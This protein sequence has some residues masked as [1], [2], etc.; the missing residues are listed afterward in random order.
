ML[1]R[2]GRKFYLT[3]TEVHPGERH[4]YSM[5][6][7]GGARTR[8]TTMTGSNEAEV[9]PDDGMLGIVYSY[10]NKP[11]EVFLMANAPG[12]TR[13]ADHD[14]ADSGVAGRSS[15]STPRSSPTRRATGST[16]TRVS[17]RPR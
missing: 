8:I 11:P 1:S 14:D 4:L 5:A 3:T 10:S 2:D 9:S 17:S 6:V 12:A 13:H 16:S 7:D 15:G